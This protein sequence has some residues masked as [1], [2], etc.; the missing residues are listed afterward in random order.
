MIEY[1]LKLDIRESDL[2]DKIPKMLEDN[3]IENVKIINCSLDIGDIIIENNKEEE[4]IIIER[5]TIN[6]LASSIQD[7][8]YNEQSLRLN[9]TDVH[10][11]NI[12]YIIE[13]SVEKYKNNYSRIKKDTI[14]SS[15]F[16]LNYYKGFSVIRSDNTDETA[17]ILVKI[18]KKMLRDTTKKGYYNNIKQEKIDIQNKSQP[19]YSDVIKRVKKENIKP[20]NIGSIILSQIPGISKKISSIIMEKYGSLY[21]L[22]IILHENPNAL[23]N[24]TYV[25]DKG[26]K[27]RINHKCI[28]SINDYLLYKKENI[29]NIDTKN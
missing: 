17:T 25:T 21:E 3:K 1:I 5:K 15:I 16:S 6:D 12:Y 4:L 7:G 9:S 26:Q 10:N 29:V 28:Q 22:M 18:L 19:Q 2:I 24:E 8:R 20:N 14:Y 13:G 23:K 11:H 27:R